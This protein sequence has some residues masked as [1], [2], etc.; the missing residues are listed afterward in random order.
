MPI[1]ATAET[2]LARTEGFDGIID[3]VR[4]YNKPLSAAEIADIALVFLPIGDK[5]TSE[6]EELSF[7][8]RTKSGS[9]AEI[10]DNNLPSTPYLASNIFRWTPDYNDAGVYEVE[11]TAPHGGSVDFETITVTVTDSQQQGPVG[12][13]RFD[14]NIGDIAYDSSIIGN[15]GYLRNG[16]AWDSGRINGALAFSVSNDAV[17]IQTTA[18][19]PHSGTIA[20]WVYPQIQTLSRHYLFGHAD[21]GLTDRLQLY[22]KY[23]NLCL[24]LGDSHE[25]KMD[26][27]QLYTD[28]WYHVAV[29][30]SNASYNV[31]VNGVLMASGTYSGLSAFTKNA[32]IGNNGMTRDKAFN[33]KIDEV[34]VY[35]RA[36]N[37][38]EISQLFN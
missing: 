11:F 35:N 26:I 15:T 23:G 14:D 17:E 8:V 22:L 19:N 4:L 25:T 34:R 18:F 12:Y 7:A 6:G 37:A 27:Q 21:N 32:D 29:T 28:Q 31:Y 38:L 30:W 36:L 33:G 2:A 3:E 16:L 1:S 9:N 10:T 13:W 20:M 24:G 5:S